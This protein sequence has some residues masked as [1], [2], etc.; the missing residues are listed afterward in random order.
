MLRYEELLDSPECPY[1][2]SLENKA[3]DECPGKPP[4]P[5]MMIISSTSTHV[6]EVRL[7]S[8][9][10]RLHTPETES[11]QD[12]E[13]VRL[14]AVLEGGGEMEVSRS[15]FPA[16]IVDNRPSD[17]TR[18]AACGKEIPPGSGVAYKGSMYHRA[19]CFVE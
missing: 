7:H 11:V 1:Q 5:A 10:V 12:M 8:M 14:I 15:S 16:E 9:R 3:G 6:R 4:Y 13:I 18:C 2:F 19:T 17:P